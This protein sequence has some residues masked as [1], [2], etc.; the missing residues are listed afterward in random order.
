MKNIMLAVWWCS[1]YRWR[2]VDWSQVFPAVRPVADARQTFSSSRL[3]QQQQQQW[4]W[5]RWHCGICVRLWS[6][7]TNDWLD[8]QLGTEASVD[9]FCC[10]GSRWKK[11]NIYCSRIYVL[12]CFHLHSSFWFTELSFWFF[13]DICSSFFLHPIIVQ[14]LEPL[15]DANM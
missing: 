6:A 15:S 2:G 13:R 1:D 8:R 4:R 3:C 9:A 5:R 7:N 14:K 12:L 10:T 11:W